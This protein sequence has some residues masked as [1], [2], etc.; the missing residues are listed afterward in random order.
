VGIKFPQGYLLQNVITLIIENV[1]EQPS[2]WDSIKHKVRA[3]VKHGV[4]TYH[5]DRLNVQL[6][7]IQSKFESIWQ[8]TKQYQSNNFEE[9]LFK[10]L[11]EMFNDRH[12]YFP[13]S[14]ENSITYMGNVVVS[15]TKYVTI[16]MALAKEIENLYASKNV[17]G[18]LRTAQAKKRKF[19][20]DAKAAAEKAFV[21]ALNKR[22]EQL[23]TSESAPY[24]IIDEVTGNQ[25]NFKYYESAGHSARKRLRLVLQQ[26]LVQPLNTFLQLEGL[27]MI[28][29][30]PET[31]LYP[32]TIGGFHC[33][34]PCLQMGYS[35]YW[36]GRRWD[37][38]RWDYCSPPRPATSGGRQKTIRGEDCK[39]ECTFY[40]ENYYYCET[41][42]SW[43]YCSLSEPY[44][45]FLSP[46]AE[47]FFYGRSP[48]RCLLWKTIG[49][50][51]SPKKSTCSSAGQGWNLVVFHTFLSE[52]PEEGK[53]LYSAFEKEIAKF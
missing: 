36:C 44:S 48:D 41:E 42:S 5:V 8:Y 4:T 24:R 29:L 52:N 9:E 13:T 31:T 50:I 47:S 35:Y 18:K 49:E 10:L 3:E 26:V 34:T 16:F 28:E 40:N 27:A 37:N 15:M 6:K 14:F 12:D 43:D 1:L 11:Q 21:W 30:P 39:G 25:L 38:N 53:K 22:L 19:L 33:E 20:L 17:D 45:E 2:I 23:V 51:L 32:L 7:R 46:L